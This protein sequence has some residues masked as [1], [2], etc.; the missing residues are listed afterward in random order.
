MTEVKYKREGDRASDFAT[1]EAVR[2]ER[3]GRINEALSRMHEEWK[4]PRHD[5]FN[6]RLFPWLSSVYPRTPLYAT[7][8]WEYPWAVCHAKLSPGMTCADV[9]CGMTAFTPYLA[10][11]QRCEVTG[12]DPDI[13]GE[14]FPKGAFGVN[15]DLLKRS[16]VTFQPCGM[17]S[18]AAHDDSFDRVFCISVLEHVPSDVAIRGVRE[19][20]RILKP[21]GLAVITMDLCISE[22][23][24]SLNPLHLIWESGLVPAGK[25]D[26]TWPTRRF[27]H[28]YKRGYAADVFGM[29]LLKDADTVDVRYD[30]KDHREDS[31]IERWRIPVCRRKAPRDQ[32]PFSFWKRLQLARKLV[33][34]SYDDVL[35]RLSCDDMERFS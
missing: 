25:L 31:R 35:K 24:T 3:F 23:V 27:G 8:V 16:H 22:T 18:L 30:E 29:V 4:L 6:E 26:L 14:G 7:R 19:M 34:G 13:V 1:V 20:A 33:L 32:R 28:Y 11:D 2:T 21:G 5:E 15:P 10:I 17:E 9:G 12:F